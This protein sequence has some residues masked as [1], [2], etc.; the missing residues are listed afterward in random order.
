M[1]KIILLLSLVFLTLTANAQ[2]L[3]GKAGVGGKGGFG[4][5]NTS[6]FAGNITLAGTTFVSEV[7]TGAIASISTATSGCPST[8]GGTMTVS[9]GGIIWGF[10]RDG[11]GSGGTIP[12]TDSLGNVFHAVGPPTFTVQSNGSIGTAQLSEAIVTVPGSDNG[13]CTPATSQNFQSSVFTFFSASPSFSSLDT[14][15]GSNSTSTGTTFTSGNYTTTTAGLIYTCVTRGQTGGAVWS[16]GNIG[17]VGATIAMTSSGSVP[18][19]GD[20]ACEY[21]V[22]SNPQTNI[23]SSMTYGSAVGNASITGAAH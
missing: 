5:G 17:G 15:T 4:G 10:C 12:S 14:S 3:G 19:N 20:S 23:T 1:K 6:A 13:I 7:N 21:L 18:G 8:C 22:T 11:D 2:G 9:S 16:A